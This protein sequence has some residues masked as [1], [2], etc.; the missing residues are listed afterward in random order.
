MILQLDD[1][2][3]IRV[4]ARVEERRPRLRVRS[5]RLLR[6]TFG[7]VIGLETE[8]DCQ[9]VIDSLRKVLAAGE[10]DV[11]VLS[12]LDVKSPLYNAA[13]ADAE[14][15]QPDPS[16]RIFVHWSADLP[17]SFAEF[18]AARSSKT[19]SNLRYYSKKVLQTYGDTLE[20][21]ALNG[22]G[23]LDR[24]HRDMEHIAARTYQ[25]G[26]GVGYTGDSMQTALIELAARRGSLRAW[27]V[28]IAKVPVAFWFGYRYRETFLSIANAFDPMFGDVRIGQHLQMEV[29]A[30][31]CEDP[32]IRVFDWGVGGA[33]YK[34]RFGDHVT[35][36]TDVIVLRRSLRG[37]R[38][39]AEI[40]VSTAA[41]AGMRWLVATTGLGARTKRIW[42]KQA[43]RRAR[44]VAMAATPRQD[45]EASAKEQPCT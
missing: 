15:W 8:S 17:S 14:W 6:V 37:R 44:R 5:R 12:H 10:A 35:S 1:G 43:E 34:R 18:L 2:R 13:Q 19:R 3:E 16:A 29:M 33:E 42:R 11:L 32:D 36:E 7:G 20:I 38:I 27:V 40:M 45:H 4:V 21:R 30:S 39:A 28:Y 24:L 22:V 41:K 23:D 26:L 31:L 9:C 25:R